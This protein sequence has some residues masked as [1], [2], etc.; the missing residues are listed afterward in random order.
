MSVDCFV[1]QVIC[2]V[3]DR[4]DSLH[5]FLLKSWSV[6]WIILRALPFSACPWSGA[7]SHAW[8]SQ[9]GLEIYWEW[10]CEN[11]QDPIIM[12]YYKGIWGDFRPFMPSQSHVWLCILHVLPGSPS[13]YIGTLD[14]QVHPASVVDLQTPGSVNVQQIG[15]DSGTATAHRIQKD[16]AEMRKTFLCDYCDARFATYS[17][18]WKHKH[19]IH[20]KK[21]RTH[22]CTVC[23]KGFLDRTHYVDHTNMH[24]D[25]QAHKCPYCPSQFTYKGNLYTHIRSVHRKQYAIKK[26]MS[27][28]A[29]WTWN[30]RLLNSPVLTR[31]STFAHLAVMQ[32]LVHAV[33]VLVV[34][35][36]ECVM[37]FVLPRLS[38]SVVWVQRCTKKLLF[39]F[40]LDSFQ[41][42]NDHPWICA[43]LPPVWH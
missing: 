42:W 30:A 16:F 9:A 15:H 35:N 23:G 10:Q 20:L 43:P 12:V 40:L 1:W 31:Y 32:S 37:C 21:T 26:K 22:V 8:D 27:Q 33:S 25:I 7:D 39:C 3:V 34:C 41:S 13:G 28:A 2:I 24:K 38:V 5:H 19:I 4:F 11:L 18:L 6:L 29:G 17:G 36:Q 14:G